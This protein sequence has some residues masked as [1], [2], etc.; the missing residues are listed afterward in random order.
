MKGY[1]IMKLYQQQLQTHNKRL[2]KQEQLAIELAIRL[3]DYQ[4]NEIDRLQQRIKDL[5]EQL[6]CL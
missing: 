3:L 4:N 2:T 6:N 1:A 5:Q